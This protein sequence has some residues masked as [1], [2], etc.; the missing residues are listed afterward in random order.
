MRGVVAFIPARSGSRGLKHKNIRPLGG[1]PLIAWAIS[2]AKGSKYIDRIIV[3]T[4]SQEYARIAVEHGAEVPF[5]RPPE[6]AEDVPTE[7]VIIHAV[8]ELESTGYNVELPITIQCTTPLL[9]SEYIDMAIE[10]VLN[11]DYADSAMTV[12]E[13]SDRP[14]WMFK[15]ENGMLK[16]FL[17][18]PLKGE[19]GV[20]QTLTKLY[21]PNGACYVT[22][23]NLL[24][25]EKRIIG[26]RCIPIIM[27]RI[28]SLDIDDIEDFMLVEAVVNAGIHLKIFK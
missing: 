12:C 21:R 1:K 6:L 11:N 18:V 8:N 17:D 26:N 19:W 28:L 9:K 13:I 3:S 16:P 4:D 23:K 25:N 24:M 20:R 27:P 2:A 22:R 14:E 5:L 10:S 7:D 15:I